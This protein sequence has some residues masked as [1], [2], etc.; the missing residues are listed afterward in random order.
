MMKH[1]R[2]YICFFIF[3]FTTLL[4]AR[5]IQINYTPAFA[6]QTSTFSLTPPAQ[7]LSGTLTITKGKAEKL[8]RTSPAYEETSTGAQILI[9]ESVTTKENSTATVSVANIVTTVLGSKSELVYANLFADNMLLFQKA[10]TITFD[11][12]TDKQLSV[13]ALHAL[14]SIT[15]GSTT[16]NIIDSDLSVSINTGSAKVALVDTDNNTRVWHLK[17]GQWISLNDT[18][19]EVRLKGKR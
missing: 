14:I 19:R 18:T 8:S 5:S 4:I 1:T 6:P 17:E 10:G 11:V 2:Y 9:G 7:A 3:G 16:V 13:R 15:S 12:A